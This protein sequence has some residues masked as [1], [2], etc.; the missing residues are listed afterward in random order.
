LGDKYDDLKEYLQTTH[1]FKPLKRSYMNKKY[2]KRVYS[3]DMW[4]EFLKEFERHNPNSVP[5]ITV[6]GKNEFNIREQLLPV[7]RT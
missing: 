6:I 2:V 1:N 7:P 4:D 5:K 3:E